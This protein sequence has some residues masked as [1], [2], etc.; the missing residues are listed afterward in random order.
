MPTVTRLAAGVGG[1]SAPLHRLKAETID[2]PGPGV[3]YEALG[4]GYLWTVVGPYTIPGEDDRLSVIDVASKQ[5]V[6]SVRLGHPTT[7]LAYG[8]GAAW[9]G[10]E[11]SEAKEQHTLNGSIAPGASR[12]EEIQAD[13]QRPYHGLGQPYL[14]RHPL[15][16]LLE[17]GDTAGPTS[18]AV[19]E[20]AVWVLMCGTCSI[21]TNHKTLLEID[22]DTLKVLKR[23]PL[24]RYTDYLAVGAGSV[25]LTAYKD[26]SVWQLD[27][28]TG[29]VLRA[30]PL[31]RTSGVTCAITATPKAVWVA[32]GD[33]SC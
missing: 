29:R 16:R 30:I 12:L 26:G 23:I 20:G 21:G 32:V 4:G 27:P 6:D 25:W 11:G 19:G 33:A 24:H 31:H 9:V 18:I 5:V 17:T 28:A 3:G 10:T 13:V 22:P 7:A 1:P 15:R 2:V 14:D 8:Y